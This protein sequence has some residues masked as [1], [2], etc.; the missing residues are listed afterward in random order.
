MAGRVRRHLTIEFEVD[1]DADERWWDFLD[2]AAEAGIDI[3]ETA[4]EACD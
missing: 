1:D 3:V 2:A 4:E